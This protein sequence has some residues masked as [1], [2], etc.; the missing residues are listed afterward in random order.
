M[1]KITLNWNPP[2]DSSGG[3]ATSYKIYRVNG[4]ETNGSTIVSTGTNIANP[5]HSG[6]ATAPQTYP[7]N[8]AAHGS[9][10]SYTILGKN[11]AGLSEDPATPVTA[12]A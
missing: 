1:A 7:D 4:A 8:T 3:S 9:E 6:S 5:D 10:Y 12:T 11:A 2:S